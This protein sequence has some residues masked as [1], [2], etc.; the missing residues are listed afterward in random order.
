[1]VTFSKRQRRNKDGY[2]LNHFIMMT[3]FRIHVFVPK[4]DDNKNEEI[5]KEG[6]NKQPILLERSKERNRST[7]AKTPYSL[8]QGTSFDHLHGLGS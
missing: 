4:V 2:L 6:Q 8:K 3:K 7:F 5:Y 1:M